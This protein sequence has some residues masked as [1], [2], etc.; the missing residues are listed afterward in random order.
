MQVLWKEDT[1]DMGVKKTNRST[2]R[3][4]NVEEVSKP[5][6]RLSRRE[7]NEKLIKSLIYASLVLAGIA[8]FKE[9]SPGTF[10]ALCPKDYF[11]LRRCPFDALVLDAGGFP[12]LI[13]SKCVAWVAETTQFKWRKCGLCLKGCPTRALTVLNQRKEQKKHTI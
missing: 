2:G 3:P 1:W 5:E 8:L 7:F 11:C 13:R 9:S 10:K 4:K 6:T 12:K